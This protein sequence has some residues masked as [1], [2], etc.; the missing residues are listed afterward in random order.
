ML[1]R[2]TRL[3]REASKILYGGLGA[4]ASLPRE[5]Y[6][7]DFPTNRSSQSDNLLLDFAESLADVLYT[8]AKVFDIEKLW[9][10]TAPKEADGA[11]IIDFVGDIF[12]LLSAK[13]QFEL[14]GSKLYTR[15]KEQDEGRLPF[16]DPSPS[17]RWIWG[18]EQSK[19]SIDEA[20]HNMSIFNS[21]WHSYGQASGADSC[22]DSLFVYPQSTGDT[23]YRDGSYPIDAPGIPSGFAIDRVPSFVGSPD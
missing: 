19:T 10:Y 1:T 16:I 6:L 17:I 14:V 11:R 23:T 21:W 22:S 5:I 8:T 2:S 13:K 3:L 9:N 12:P 20:F 7:V 4:I 18:A 15:H